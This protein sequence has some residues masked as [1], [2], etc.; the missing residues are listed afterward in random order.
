M[1]VNSRP[2]DLI[3]RTDPISTAFLLVPAFR[4]ALRPESALC[5]YKIIDNIIHKQL[6]LIAIDDPSPVLYYI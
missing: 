1:R 4:T 2:L 3:Y 5:N 6:L